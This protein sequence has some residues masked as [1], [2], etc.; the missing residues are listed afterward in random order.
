[1]YFN[2]T[3]AHLGQNVLYLYSFIHSLP[4]DSFVEAEIFRRDITYK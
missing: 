4:V 3:L 2:S 1:M